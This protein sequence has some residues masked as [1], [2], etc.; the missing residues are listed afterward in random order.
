MGLTNLLFSAFRV[1]TVHV[2]SQKELSM[3]QNQL[4]QPHVDYL[5]GWEDAMR[6]GLMGGRPFSEISVRTYAYYTEWFLG[7]YGSLTVESLKKALIAI[8]IEHF[9]KRLKLFQ[10]LT[11][12]AKYLMQEGALDEV[13][14]V[15]A[16]KFK[17]RRHL[18]ERKITVDQKG[19]DKLLEACQSPLERLIVILLSQTG[20]RVSEAANLCLEDID[21]ENRFV[22]VKLAKWGKTRR[23]GLL[24]SVM[25]A[26]QAH[27][28]FR[29]KVEEDWLFIN[30]NGERM[31][32]YGIRNR[33]E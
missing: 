13:Y 18:P 29:P 6:F 31:D 22:R 17:P 3:K 4:K 16:K 11:S 1:M 10:S 33:L 24:A 28:A 23:V 20:L 14:L 26:I 21:F 19:L 30:R 8:P 15:Q 9:A 25:T 5:R 12:F 7:Q 27:L 32:R 2:S